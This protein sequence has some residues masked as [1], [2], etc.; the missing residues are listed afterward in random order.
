V[1]SSSSDVTLTAGANAPIVLSL[2][3]DFA[4][5]RVAWFFD[6]G[7]GGVPSND[8]AAAGAATINVQ[9]TDNAG[10]VQ[11]GAT[12]ACADGAGTING[13]G[14]GDHIFV[15]DARDGNGNRVF[16]DL[17]GRAAAL[18]L[19]DNDVAVTLSPSFATATV[20][21]LFNVGSGIATNDC[22]IAGAATVSV[23]VLNANVGNTETG[24]TFPCADGTGT[25]EGLTT[26]NHSFVLT[27]F[28][29]VG[30]RV[31]QQLT[32][33]NTVLVAGANEINISL[34]PAFASVR[35]FWQFNNGSITSDCA[36]VGVTNVT[37]QAIDSS[38]VARGGSTFLCVE[39]VGVIS[40]LPP[41]GYRIVGDGFNDVGTRVFQER[42]GAPRGV[43]ATLDLGTTDVVIV[44]EQ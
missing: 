43:N 5:A 14:A 4:R 31:F 33:N 1:A 6:D 26:G 17:A 11:A 8:C 13:L 34:D 27:G 30:T 10:N 16:D 18:N 15:A 22:G 41:D 44:L 38:G 24:A 25:I 20:S 2:A 23:Q 35:V 19:G 42:T 12:F 3:P 32:P 40:G 9:V 21:W 28:D 29:A 39:G 37:V 36:A 7:T